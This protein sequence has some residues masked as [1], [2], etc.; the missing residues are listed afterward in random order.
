MFECQLILL[1]GLSE[2]EII[3]TPPLTRVA[4]TTSLPYIL[5]FSEVN[6]E[7]GLKWVFERESNT[8]WMLIVCAKVWFVDTGTADIAIPLENSF[9]FCESLFSLSFYYW[10]RSENH[11]FSDRLRCNFVRVLFQTTWYWLPIS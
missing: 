7:L 1:V 11:L 9:H 4:R 10:F 6:C 8:K 5:H 2:E 3:S